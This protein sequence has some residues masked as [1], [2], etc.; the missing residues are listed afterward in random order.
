MLANANYKEAP[1]RGWNGTNVR[2]MFVSG[3]HWLDENRSLPNAM[4]VFPVPDGDTGTNLS[5]TLH[6]GLSELA[7]A[8]SSAS[9][10]LNTI[11]HETL[12]HARGNG[13]VIFTQI[14]RGLAN[15]VG[16]NDILYPPIMIKALK[17]ASEVA[18]KALVRPVEGTILTVIRES[19]ESLSSNDFDNMTDLLKVVVSR[20]LVSEA[21]T[22]SK[23]NV[24]DMAGVVD[25]GG[26]GLTLFLEG[27]L[28][29]A[30]GRPV[31]KP[32][33]TK[34]KTE[35]ILNIKTF[36]DI[37]K[38]E[39]RILE[40]S[41]NGEVTTTTA[42]LIHYFLK[43][44]SFLSEGT[45]SPSHRKWLRS[46]S[47]YWASLIAVHLD[48]YP[49]I[50]L[51][52]PEQI[53]VDSWTRISKRAFPSYILESA[54]QPGVVRNFPVIAIVSGD[55]LK[56][57]FSE[58]GCNRVVDGG[59]TLNPS[60]SEIIDAINS[61]EAD[62]IVLLPNS[63]KS[64]AVAKIIQEGFQLRRRLTLLPTTSMLAGISALLAINPSQTFDSNLELMNLAISG[65]RIIEITTA[66]RDTVIKD[67]QIQSGKFMAIF[68]GEIV[69][70][71]WSLEKTFESLKLIFPETLRILDIYFGEDVSIRMAR[72]MFE[73]ALIMLPGVEI[74]LVNGGQSNYSLL[75]S[76]Q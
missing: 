17:N 14:I 59:E 57:I 56:H 13:G 39:G 2:D 37:K 35:D 25:A 46:A 43:Q 65:T 60:T 34:E 30:E 36:S 73:K 23:L 4:N 53:L 72:L 18:Y 5:L 10:A 48:Y 75:I 42:S 27:A 67:K 7:D 12:M 24:L 54:K 16:D 62:N 58:L 61:I 33:V 40:A 26:L 50:S 74:N 51:F 49:Y 41:E 55:G 28:R 15:G 71:D 31:L 29:W 64:L 45:I 8:P 19:T 68:E 21:Q 9:V 44:C 47:S 63:K 69:A 20:S 66:V 11:A 1:S 38:F 52:S 70:S 6:G 76:F 22:P 32:N 3:Y